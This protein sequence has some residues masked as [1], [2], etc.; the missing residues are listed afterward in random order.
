MRLVIFSVF[1]VSFGFLFSQSSQQQWDQIKDLTKPVV[2]EDF[3][4]Q[5]QEPYRQELSSYGWEDGVH[6]SRDG[7]NL[8][9][10]Y[11]PGDLLAWTLSFG[12]RVGSS[13][14]CELFAD[15]TFLRSYANFYGMDMKTNALGCTDFLN[16][17]IL[18]ARRTNTFL[19]FSQWN[20]S[21]IARSGAVEG[22]PY[23]L[24]SLD[25]QQLDIFLFTNNS[26]IW[27]LRNTTFNPSQINTATRLP[28]PINPVTNEFEA[29]NPH[30]ERL[31]K[32]T[33]LLIYEKYTDS[34]KRDFM[35]TTSFDNGNTW[36][37]PIKITTVHH[38]LGK[39]EHPHLYQDSQKQWYLY[40]SLGCDIYRSKQQKMNDWD[41]WGTPEK[42]IDKGNSPCIGEPTLTTNG[43]IS[44]VV[45]TVNIANNDSTDTYDI[46]PWFLP[47][48]QVIS[49]VGHSKNETVIYPQPFENKII[50]ESQ[51]EITQIIVYNNLGQVVI[52]QN[53]NANK[54][55]LITN[56]LKTG[57]YVLKIVN[58]QEII[59]K[60]I[61]KQ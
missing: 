53:I 57:M 35:Y 33:L 50:V 24:F 55:A 28:S 19:P 1:F 15:T 17:D 22:S 30:L 6:I 31:G 41:S 59:T 26:D 13:T 7:L 32:D 21:N 42:I 58:N 11:Y 49:S 38:G 54:T 39:I 44:F 37:T 14:F 29:D 51:T 3:K 2:A 34:E 48:K 12:K 40:Y 18:Y 60:Q 43:D 10:L 36:E 56:E 25:E 4:S 16:V 20:L 47:I 46:D 27:M 9:A 61:I 23:P 52:N 5:Y 45:V 8:Y